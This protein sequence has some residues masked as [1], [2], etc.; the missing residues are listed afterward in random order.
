MITETKSFAICLENMDLSQIQLEKVHLNV[1]QLPKSLFIDIGLHL[2]A[3]KNFLR[4]NNSINLDIYTPFSVAD[5]GII[6]L[7]GI[8]KDKIIAQL[9]FN[10][11]VTRI[12]PMNKV[13]QNESAYLMSFRNREALLLLKV[14]SNQIEK[15]KISVTINTDDL[16]HTDIK[17]ECDCYIRFRFK[18]DLASSNICTSQDGGFSEK[19]FYD[20]R[21]N[22]MRL[23]PENELT[24]IQKNIFSIKNLYVFVIQEFDN[25]IVLY[26]NKLKYMRFLEKNYFSKY[27]TG[28]SGL[29]NEF[30][31]YYWNFSTKREENPQTPNSYNMVVGFERQKVSFKQ[32]QAGVLVNILSACILYVIET[33][34]KYISKTTNNNALFSLTSDIIS[35]VFLLLFVGS[36]LFG[37][38]SLT[39]FAFSLLK[40][41]KRYFSKRC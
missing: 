40:S 34:N 10:D 36:I 32:F 15:N 20:I 4:K 13:P 8:L 11:E 33:F 26:E 31:I 16:K 7:F 5:N 27:L 23:L 19:T 30:I 18:S 21:F 2:K 35:S 9:I 17:D 29:K 37:L 6:D 3:K 39:K 38:W 12:E 24:S 25:K 28:L 22:E 41:N 14:K 1:W